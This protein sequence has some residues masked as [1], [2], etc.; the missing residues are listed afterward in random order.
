MPNDVSTI[1]SFVEA[2]SAHAE[3]HPLIAQ[4]RT[5][6]AFSSQLVGP[7]TL[8]TLL[9]AARWAPSSRDEQPWSFIIATRDKPAEFERLLQ[10]LLEF[11]IRWAQHA[12]VL[13][14]VVAKLNLMVSGE[15]N[16]HAFYDVGQAMAA[17]T[18]QAS[19][20]ALTVSQ[21]AGFDTQ[22]A[23]EVFSIPADHEP[24]VAAAI[25]YQGDPAVLSEKLRQK[26]LAPRKR[27]A[28]E[29]FVFENKWGQPA[30]WV[31]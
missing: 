6:R 21:M 1:P 24:V 27:N 10:C 28:M 25:G 11:N 29:E 14:L 4:R 23:R 5:H 17:M 22:K 2:T 18:F 19:A 3:L 20:L 8:R 15:R 7:E 31:K 12:P 13:M 16:P 9:E 26:E 30:G